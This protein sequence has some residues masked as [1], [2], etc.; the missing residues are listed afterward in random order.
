MALPLF[1]FGCS[2]GSD[3][4]PGTSFGTLT[5]SVIDTF[6]NKVA[7]VTVTPSPAVDSL[8]GGRVSTAADGTY[9]MTLP[10]GN[11]TLTFANAAYVTQTL[12]VSVVATQT[13]QNATITLVPKAAAAVTVTGPSTFPAAGSVTLTAAPVPLDPAL[14]GKPATFEWKDQRGNVLGTSASV[15]INRPTTAEL[16]ANVAKEVAPLES[17]E[18]NPANAPDEEGE[19]GD[20]F[21]DI[22]V[23]KTLDRLMV[24]GIPMKAY[25]NA[26]NPTYTVAVTISGQTFTQTVAVGAGTAGLPFVANPGLRNVPIGQPLMLQGPDSGGTQT[27]WNFTLT[28][29]AG[30]AASLDLIDKTTRF[31]HFTPDV[32]G[33]YTVAETV[34][35][36]SM[37][38]YAG[39]WVGI[40]RPAV[41]GSDDPRGDVDPGCLI[42][43]GGL[44][45]SAATLA[46]FTEWR[47]S[48]HSEV[49]VVGMAEG[50]HYNVNSCANCH[51]VGGTYLGADTSA[52]SFRN[53]IAAAGFTNATFLSKLVPSLD[54]AVI[55][56]SK[57]FQGFPQVLQ[58]SEVQCEN[59][60]GP[61]SNGEVHGAGQPDP[62]D[63]KAARVSFSSDV[64]APCHG[65]P[66][67]HGRYQEWRES[68]HGDF[69]TAIGE[70]LGSGGVGANANCAGCHSGQGFPYLL[71]QLQSGNPLR[72]LNAASL[73]ALSF[74]RA[75]NVQPITC[76][77]CHTP[78]DAGKQPGLVGNVVN[79]RGD[80]QSGGAFDGNTPLLPAG[81]QANGVGRGALCI[82]CHNSRNGGSGTTVGLHED[83][84]PIFGTF[85]SYASP[86]EAAQG[87]VLMGRN[88]YFFG[89][90]QIGQRSKHSLL[91]DACVT[92]HLEKT[93][94]DPACRCWPND[95]RR[96]DEPLLR[97]H[98]RSDA[99]G[100]G[101]GQRP[102]PEVPR[103]FRGHGCPEDL[104]TPPITTCWRKSRKRSCGSSSAA[105]GRS[106]PGRRWSSSRDV[107]RRFL[108]TAGPMSIWRPISPT[109]RVHRQR[110][111]SRR[112]ASRSTSRRRTGTPRWFLSM[113]AKGCT[114][115]ASPWMSSQ[116][117]SRG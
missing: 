82:T 22:R 56:K 31:P 59:C 60:H 50:S 41:D 103:R 111:P 47:K 13:K 44:C 57:F 35:G 52:G 45:H 2:S 64:C 94:A 63:A 92:C 24:V 28:K 11:Y 38:I 84:D 91:A 26:A 113:Q 68:G 40:L 29:P 65:E 10:T 48:G 61:N 37:K 70:G 76:V 12:S 9:S 53:V 95:R 20:H 77:T 102:L 19:E 115:R 96:R 16:K 117:R 99:D 51:S 75:D 74:L 69:E 106:R 79:L 42:G 7:N 36:K 80:F 3:G 105:P 21:K 112:L 89:S 6:N 54:E 104:I 8:P 46:K 71:G 55:E 25:E 15:T 98:H 109:P 100:G 58:L 34:S 67:R 62:A 23:F 73:A 87:D 66:L 78:H 14:V 5:G 17:I 39:K 1:L 88:A 33:T 86:H 49:M 83:G 18:P 27:T 72:T 81:F 43:G 101:A 116:R 108:S 97:H 90:G 107:R 114:I 85:T 4:A 30:S 32:V 93:P 110:V